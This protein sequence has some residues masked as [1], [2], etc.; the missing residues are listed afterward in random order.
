[1]LRWRTD[2]REREDARIILDMK[3]KLGLQNYQPNTLRESLQHY[4]RLLRH[5]FDNDR[6][7]KKMDLKR[8]LETE[9][10]KDWGTPGSKLMLLH[11]RNASSVGTEHCW[12]SLVAAELAEKL[13]ESG[14]PVAYEGCSRSSTLELTMSRLVYQLLERD[15]SLI[16]RAD[17]FLEIASQLSQKDMG[18]GKIDTLRT[19]LLRIINLHSNSQVYIILNRPELS[20]GSRAQ[21]IETMLALVRDTTA[22]LK[23]MMV[24]RSEIWDANENEKEIYI[25]GISPDRFQ[26]VSLDQD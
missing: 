26:R 11:G 12:L 9:H 14:I 24:Q 25:H 10:G 2:L 16:R 1:M 23:V 13:F 7:H 21:C 8:F 18:A 3:G 15:P 22:Q 4:Q 17:D 20:E 19:A 5:H 6:R